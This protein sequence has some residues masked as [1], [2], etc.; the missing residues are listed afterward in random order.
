MTT[1]LIG[2]FGLSFFLTWF[3]SVVNCLWEEKGN[4]QGLGLTGVVY[5][6]LTAI[7]FIYGGI[8]GVYPKKADKSIPIAGITLENGMWERMSDSDL[9]VSEIFDLKPAKYAELMGSP[10]SHLDEMRQKTLEAAEAGAKLVIWQEFALT[11]ESSSADAYLLEMR[12]LADDRDIYLLVSYARILNETEKKDRPEKNMG[13]LFTPDG[14][15]GWEYAKAFPCPGYE[16]CVVEAGPRDIPHMDTPY[17]RIGQAVCSDMFLPHYIRQAAAKSIDL[18][19]VPSMDAAMFTPLYAFGSWYRAVENGF[20]M[21]RIAGGGYTAVIDPYFRLWAAH[22]VPEI[23]STNFYANI[24]VVSKKTFY[25]RIGFVF[26]YI[27]LVLL[28]S[29]VVLALLRTAH[30]AKPRRA[31]G[32]EGQN[33]RRKS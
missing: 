28:I 15:I 33:R 6:S 29:L 9:Y 23:G 25:A 21:V 17:G 22:S 2:V 26:P 13:V 27:V 8:A 30:K 24:P 20:T 7:V 14:E 19:L 18:L 4:I 31:P 32:M 3:A 1:S 12:R 16:E 10:Q 11:L 5:V